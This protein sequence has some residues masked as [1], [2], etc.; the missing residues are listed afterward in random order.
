[1]EITLKTYMIVC[2]LVF[3]AGF[4]D[5]VAGGGGI[6]SLPA[7]V[8][9]GIP[10]H[11]AHGC[12]K[13][14]N[15]FGT[16]LAT[17]QFAKS[18]YIRFKPA[19]MAAAGALIGGWIGS[20]IVLM[21]SAEALQM[22]LMICL[23]IV[24]VFMLTRK[25]IGSDVDNVVEPK[26]EYTLSFVIGLAT[27]CYDGIFGPGTGTF[28]LLS[29]TAFLGYAMITA[30]AN[31]KAANLASN[32]GALISYTIGG[33]IIYS[34]ALPCMVCSCLGNFIGSRLAIKNGSKFIRPVIFVVM[35]LLFAK[36]FFDFVISR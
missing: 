35:T 12:N 23:P 15:S 11:Y 24:A 21:L 9:A 26:K 22:M 29:F 27:G 5:A 8:L 33:N 2:P 10:V 19:L 32:V 18:G 13:T 34:V 36:I 14:A 31:A 28:M 6:I 4:I 16:A 3:L 20:Q 7:Y 1:M 30:T 17:W 25:N